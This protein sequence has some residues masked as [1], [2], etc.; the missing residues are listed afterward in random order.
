MLANL[1]VDNQ[2]ACSIALKW[3][4][5]VITQND[6]NLRVLF[7]NLILPDTL[8]DSC[9]FHVVGPNASLKY[10]GD[11]TIYS[12]ETHKVVNRLGATLPNMSAIPFELIPLKRG[13][14]VKLQRCI[15]TNDSMNCFRL[16]Q[17]H[18][19]ATKNFQVKGDTIISNDDY[20]SLRII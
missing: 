18:L 6:E 12:G 9:L 19:Q 16:I 4:T 5:L 17:E 7:G 14:Q 2:V 1:S 8:V 3:N 10:H 15:Q 11:V 20:C 13:S